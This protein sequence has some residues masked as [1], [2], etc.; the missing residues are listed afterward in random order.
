M[1][2][3]L[4]G[5]RPGFIW[6]TRRFPDYK[7]YTLCSDGDSAGNKD[8]AAH[9]RLVVALHPAAPP[10]TDLA[11]DCPFLSTRDTAG[12]F[13][14]PQS[15]RLL[16]PYGFRQGHGHPFGYTQILKTGVLLALGC[17]SNLTV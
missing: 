3:L 8:F 7:D 1:S 5:F 6:L 17:S 4:P 2:P 11:A 12:F 10:A 15:N 16:P 13:T 9:R 14:C